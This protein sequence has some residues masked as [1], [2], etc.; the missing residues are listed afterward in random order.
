[1]NIRLFFLNRQSTDSHS[2]RIEDTGEQNSATNIFRDTDINSEKERS[3]SD[4]GNFILWVGLNKEV[5][6]LILFHRVT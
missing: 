2:L 3:N 1:M 5:K 4:K 6:K